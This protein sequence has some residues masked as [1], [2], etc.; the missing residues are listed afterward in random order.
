MMDN[1]DGG[2]GGGGFGDGVRK[3]LIDSG[4]KIVLED[5]HVNS[6]NEPHEENSRHR[7]GK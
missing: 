3:A 7:R 5:A 6:M 2:G 4:T 1:G